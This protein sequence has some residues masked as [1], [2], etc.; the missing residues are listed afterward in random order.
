MPLW[1]LAPLALLGGLFALKIIYVLCT[2]L[3]L[4]K[5]RGALFVTTPQARVRAFLDAMPMEKDSLF[6]DL[7]CGDG[8]VVAGAVKRYRVRAVGYDLNPL[9]LLTA[10][11]RN[12]FMPRAKIKA[13]DFFRANLTDADYVFC[14]L[15]PDVMR[16]LSQKLALELKPGARVA[17]ANFPLP[18]WT[19]YSVI[20]PK[21]AMN[22]DPIY[23]YQVEK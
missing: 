8:R 9:A 7:G 15:F 18:G 5:T 1:I 12:L 3:V 20:K 14:Y 17:S 2:A 10:K 21:G 6:L 11:I 13:S 22:H 4:S 23:L 16:D 19:P